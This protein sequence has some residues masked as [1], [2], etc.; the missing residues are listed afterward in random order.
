MPDYD[1]PKVPPAT[2]PVIDPNVS[3]VEARELAQ[4]DGDS[5]SSGSV[6]ATEKDAAERTEL[7]KRLAKRGARDGMG[8]QGHDAATPETLLPPD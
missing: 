5:E 3:P 1:K 7:N 2:P 4:R 8:E 6:E